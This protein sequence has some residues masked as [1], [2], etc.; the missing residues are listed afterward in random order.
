MGS[1]TPSSKEGLLDEWG[2][3]QPVQVIVIIV[4]TKEWRRGL[5]L[6]VLGREEDKEVVRG[7]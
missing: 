3:A 6:E 7:G 2:L 4:V 1:H 5:G